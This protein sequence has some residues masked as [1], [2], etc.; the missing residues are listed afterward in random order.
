M[1]FLAITPKVMAQCEEPVQLPYLADVE[2]ATAPSLP[3]CMSTMWNSFA[4]Q[5]VFESSEGPVPGFTGKVLAYDTTISTEFGMPADAAV[6]VYLSTPAFEMVQGTAYKILFRYANSG[7]NL[8]IG[9]LGIYLAGPDG[10]WTDIGLI[11]NITGATP[12]DYASAEFTPPSTGIY[13]LNFAVMSEGTQGL[14]YMDDIEVQTLGIM[15][16]QDN[17]LSGLTLY[18]NPVNDILNIQYNAPVDSVELYNTAGQLLLA[19]RSN[20]SLTEINLG[21]L[22]SGVYIAH[23]NSGSK[24]EIAR[25]IKE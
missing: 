24:S 21:N 20:T 3:E 22:A 17:A 10:A 25:I 12:T 18:P 19:E 23:I 5:A 7:A 8:T 13:R 9:S 11:E 2:S 14:L 6:S 1:L 4:S 15:G 16:A